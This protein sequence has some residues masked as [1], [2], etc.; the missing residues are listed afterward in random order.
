MSFSFLRFCS[1]S[2]ISQDPVPQ[3]PVY[4]R[5]CHSLLSSIPPPPPPPTAATLGLAAITSHVDYL[6]SL[7]TGLPASTLASFSQ[8]STQQ[9]Q[10]SFK[11]GIQI[12]LLLC[13]NP[14]VV[15]PVCAWLGPHYLLDL[16][17]CC[18]PPRTPLHQ[19]WVHGVCFN[20]SA[21]LGIFLS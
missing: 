15:F 14:P 20:M 11:N 8:L 5:V 17:F 21:I 2:K 1:S 6:S 9:L 19:Y 18:S 13:S 3:C 12:M 4:F 7:L 10:Q 16:A